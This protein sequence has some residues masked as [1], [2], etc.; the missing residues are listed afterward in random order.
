MTRF[1]LRT[2]F[3]NKTLWAWPILFL[4]FAAAVFAWWD[5]APA[6]NGQTFMF[7]F[8]GATLPAGKVIPQLFSFVVLIGIIGFPN[9]FAKNIEAERAALLLSKPV[10]RSE[11]F[12]S[13]LAAMLTTSFCYTFISVVILGILV[14]IKAA[15]FPFQ[16]YLGM[17]LFFPLQLFTFYIAIVLFLILTDSYLG[18]A[19]LGWIVVGLSSFFLNSDM[20]LDKL[21]FHSTFVHTTFEVFSYFIPSAAAV[22]KITSHIFISGFSS[23][24]WSLFGFILASILPF[25]ILSYYLF[26]KKEF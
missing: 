20:I 22:H 6:Q 26:L 9:H 21:G 3:K 15:I 17:F 13:D 11:M 19:I 16:F 7:L 1:T 10:S 14:G 12:F 18:G 25:G 4:L 24:E 8:G 2:L 23:F 5:I